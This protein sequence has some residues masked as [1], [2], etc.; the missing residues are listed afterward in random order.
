MS[1]LSVLVALNY[2]VFRRKEFN[3]TAVNYIFFDMGS[4]KTTVTLVCKYL[5]NLC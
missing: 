1:S 5:N 4:S 3:G 2:G